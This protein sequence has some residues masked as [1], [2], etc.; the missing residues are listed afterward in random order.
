MINKII[1]EYKIENK[2][3]AIISCGPKALSNDLLTLCSNLNI[4][5]SNEDF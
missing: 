1:D 3:I 5:I 2:D 4:D